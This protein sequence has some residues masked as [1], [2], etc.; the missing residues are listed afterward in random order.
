MAAVEDEVTTAGKLLTATVFCR[1]QAQKLDTCLE[2]GGRCLSE[3]RAFTTCAE[4]EYARCVQTLAQ[5]AQQY[6]PNEVD[7]FQRCKARSGSCEKEDR[8]AMGCASRVVIAT[9]AA[10]KEAPASTRML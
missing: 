1:E 4:K 8:A 5:I 3:G 2:G 7:A 10:E 9:A 6:C